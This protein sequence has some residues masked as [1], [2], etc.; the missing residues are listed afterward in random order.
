[1]DKNKLFVA[2]DTLSK[3]NHIITDLKNAGTYYLVFYGTATSISWQHAYAYNYHLTPITLTA[4][5]DV[6][7][8]SGLAPL[9]V[10]FINKSSGVSGTT[11]E[12]DFKN[13]GT[14]KSTLKNPSYTY[15]A[16]G[17]YSVK[18]T[19]NDGTNTIPITKTNLITVTQDVA[20]TKLANAEYYIDNDP[21]V[22][23]AVQI[24][25]SNVSDYQLNANL[26]ISGLTNGIH[27]FGI[28]VKDS[29]GK[30][31]YTYS[32]LFIKS[33]VSDSQDKVITAA[34]YFF[35]QDPGYGN[36]KKMVSFPGTDVSII[37]TIDISGLSNGIHILMVRVQDNTGKW[38]IIYNKLFIKEQYSSNSIINITQ[39]EYFLD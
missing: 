28:R 14:A 33:D 5:F 22:G 6:N 7:V 39:A 3:N 37:S 1:M 20:T 16:P 4:D 38:S 17:I 23:S 11:Y 35:D 21:G 34:E 9:T 36:G 31:S 25:V 24:N 8:T 12:W 29:T 10:Q 15:T 2:C 19:V 13:D 18:L 30:W 27:I 32:K 26:D